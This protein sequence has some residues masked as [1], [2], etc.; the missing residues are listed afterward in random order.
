[1]PVVVDATPGSPTANSYAT[2]AEAN[3]YHETH[4]HASAWAGTEDA[5]NRA[6]VTATRLL[7]ENFRWFGWPATSNVQVLGFPRSGLYYRDGWRAIPV[8]VIPQEL[9]DATSELARHLLTSDVTAESDID[10]Q[11]ITALTAGP[12]SLQFSGAAKVGSI[13][14]P[15]V[16]RMVRHLGAEISRRSSS[17]PLVR[18]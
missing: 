10:T 3:S 4:P 2:L 13:V 14:P 6:L 17:V 9:K 5:K 11:G 18:A 1:M 7:D 15:Q 8:T 16:V 12:V